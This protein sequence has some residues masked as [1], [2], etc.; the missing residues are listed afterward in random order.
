VIAA[1]WHNAFGQAI[2]LAGDF[3]C[4]QLPG[5]EERLGQGLV[6]IFREERVLILKLEVDRVL[7]R[8][9]F[10]VIKSQQ[11]LVRVRRFHTRK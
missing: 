7:D 1:K 6:L 2:N 5:A 3:F 9:Q 11:N 10:I 4:R 8:R